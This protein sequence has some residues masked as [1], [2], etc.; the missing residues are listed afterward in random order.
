MSYPSVILAESSLV[1]YWKLNETTGSTATD[2]KSSNTGIYENNYTLNQILTLNWTKG[3][4]TPNNTY[5]IFPT[6]FQYNIS[7]LSPAVLL[8]GN[9]AYI[10]V[11]DNSNL[12]LTN[13]SMEAWFNLSSN[14]IVGDIGI[15]D[16]NA[17]PAVDTVVGPDQDQILYNPTCV[18]FAKYINNG[19]GWGLRI[20]HGF[21]EVYIGTGQWITTSITQINLLGASPPISYSKG[22]HHAVVTISSSGILNIYVDTILI[23]TATVS[24][25]LSNTNALFIGKSQNQNN[26]FNGYL[27]HCAIYNAVLTQT[28]VTAHYITAFASFYNN[29]ILSESSLISF[30]SFN[31]GINSTSQYYSGTEFIDSKDNNNGIFEPPVEFE[32]NQPGPQ[33]SYLRIPGASNI[34]A[35]SAIT[36]EMTA[37][38]DSFIINQLSDQSGQPVIFF[39]KY[40]GS[41]TSPGPGFALSAIFGGEGF[42][43]AFWTGTEW[44]DCTNTSNGQTQYFYESES[45][46]NQTV[47][48]LTLASDGT[49]TVYNNNILVKTGTVTFDLDCT[50]A[51]IL[52]A[53][54][55]ATNIVDMTVT[56]LAIYNAAL[57]YKDIT[58]HRAAFNFNL[59]SNLI[60]NYPLLVLSEP[61]ILSYWPLNDLDGVNNGS[62]V[63]TNAINSLTETDLIPNASIQ[64]AYD[65]NYNS[66]A[67]HNNGLYTGV[68]V[69][70]PRGIES[71]STGS[72]SQT[73]N[74][75]LMLLEGL[76][77]VVV[78]ATASLE[79]FTNLT[80]E[81]WCAIGNPPPPNV[82]GATI[83]GLNIYQPS[84][85]DLAIPL[86]YAIMLKSDGTKGYG[87]GIVNN[88]FQ[89]FY[90]DG[91]FDSH[92]FV[93][94]TKT[95]HYVATIDSSNNVK[96]YVDGILVQSGT[97]VSN[98]DSF[99]IALSIGP[100]CPV[101]GW[102]MFA[103]TANCAIYNAVLSASDIQIHFIYGNIGQINYGDYNY[104]LTPYALQ[105]I[106]EP[107]VIS[108]W[109]FGESDAIGG[110][111][112][113]IITDWVDSNDAYI[114]SSLAYLQ[115]INGNTTLY[116]GFYFGPM[117]W[118]SAVIAYMANAAFVTNNPGTYDS[119][120]NPAL[121]ETMYVDS[122]TNGSNLNNLTQLSMEVWFNTSASDQ[123]TIFSKYNITLPCNGFS[124]C[125]KNGLIGVYAGGN[126]V[127]GSYTI[128][129]VVNQVEV[130]G[131]GF[132]SSDFAI[133][134]TTTITI[135]LNTPNY[136]YSSGQSYSDGNFHHLVATISNTGVINIYVDS[137][138]ILTTTVTQHL[139][140]SSLL[141]I[142]ADSNTV[143][144]FTQPRGSNPIIPVAATE[145][146]PQGAQQL[147]FGINSF[148]GYL[149]HC[150]IYS[151][152]LTQTQVTNHFRL[153]YGVTPHYKLTNFIQPPLTYIQGILNEPY[154]LGYWKLS[155][156][157]G[158]TAFDFEGM[159]NGT[160]NTT[161]ILNE[162]GNNAIGPSV[163]FTG[164]NATV[165]DSI[166]LQPPFDGYPYP[167]PAAPL[168]A[169]SS[170][171]S[172]YIAGGI[173]L[174]LWIMI[175]TSSTS[176]FQFFSKNNG[177]QGYGLR[178]KN[179]TLQFFTGTEWVD[180]I[181]VIDNG[182]W[183]HIVVT[184]TTEAVTEI[185]G[186]E[187]Q[188]IFYIDGVGKGYRNS[189]YNLSCSGI[190]LVFG[191]ASN[192][193]LA[194]TAYMMH[195][196]VYGNVLSATDVATH[197]TAGTLYT[198]PTLVSI[199]PY[200]TL[201]LSETSLV[202][203][204][205]LDE[206]SG[207]TAYDS[208]DS[209]NGFYDAYINLYQRGNGFFPRSI[210][211]TNT[212]ETI[213][214]VSDNSNINALTEMTFEAW[215]LMPISSALQYI[216]Y[217][218]YEAGSLSGY[219][220]R[221][222]NHTFQFYAGNG[223]SWLDSGIIVDDN[224][225]HYVVGTIDSSGNIKTYVDGV[226]ATSAT[227][228]SQNLNSAAGSPP[229]TIGGAFTESL[230]IPMAPP[231]N[232]FAGNMAQCAIYNT[233]LTDSDILLHYQTG[234]SSQTPPVET[235]T[236]FEMS[237]MMN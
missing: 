73:V 163:K 221:V 216:F 195:C 161:Y 185:M 68:V 97:V 181:T 157:S 82:N 156:I 24:Q 203:Y 109:Q 100:W 158:T 44:F 36:I 35:F 130:T 187:G 131:P 63:Y 146:V 236:F 190:D 45:I 1:S 32:P 34:N 124:L 151:Q 106:S 5:I 74:T 51:L 43:I 166:I 120:N 7:S 108:Y 103:L 15:A 22:W 138:L 122:Y 141:F 224:N 89:F 137:I 219:A 153:G 58:E 210:N 134:G 2:S 207:S 119:P 140:N 111:A 12:H 178:V 59:D 192:G 87:I 40:S 81:A 188:I 76:G 27:M 107:T 229:L 49:I 233:V 3:V 118:Y 135:P 99:G 169:N 104:P 129:N 42:N 60:F 170:P 11:S 41:D 115:P 84:T 197:F 180:S 98:L 179:H 214:T 152:P 78:P 79:T 91:W 222:F 191:A 112:C 226:L 237:G 171:T 52:G 20:N 33:Y 125:V 88:T 150:A 95:H 175:P 86:N 17:P 92:K 105:I 147:P 116:G 47:F 50:N 208:A 232:K 121:P 155:E 220:M 201:I 176:E 70:N 202:S 46:Q 39:S 148:N 212:P 72:S 164:G 162:S 77:S 123:S 110:Y 149:M 4:E 10:H 19:A 9:T 143:S 83:P 62:A 199:T 67:V 160:Y 48:T 8:D 26:Y 117:T 223:T 227:S 23:Y 80:L 204:W 14:L 133:V 167:V 90:G 173:S 154:L 66:Q 172:G 225:W 127:L 183:H 101:F 6:E 93:N 230:L 132:A 159:D 102:D 145:V 18:I 16:L 53:N 75:K 174:E 196:A 200:S 85:Y 209:N 198:T 37:T 193:S 144:Y 168:T 205:K 136:I 126:A 194:I 139:L 25:S 55:S 182:Q 114:S 184:F 231:A 228:Y 31:E 215:I 71:D 21:V 128:N 142:G 113:N 234:T 64:V 213:V 211:V 13:L 217:G 235:Y 65:Y 69:G 206:P 94:D 218:K 30:W 96:M 28:Q 186:G 189:T 57:S 38:L 177:S 61:S 29:L 54:Q 56:N 165:P